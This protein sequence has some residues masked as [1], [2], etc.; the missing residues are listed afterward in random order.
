MER[1]AWEES[2][3]VVAG[4]LT[5]LPG[6]PDPTGSLVYRLLREIQHTRDRARPSLVHEIGQQILELLSGSLVSISSREQS[7]TLAPS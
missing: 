7:L 1:G 4:L 2:D 6:F 5:P 3:R